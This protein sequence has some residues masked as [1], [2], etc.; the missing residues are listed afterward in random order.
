MRVLRQAFPDDRPQVPQQRR[1]MRSSDSNASV[2]CPGHVV[3]FMPALRVENLLPIDLTYYLKNAD[4]RGT[5]KPG[6]VAPVV[7][8]RIYMFLMWYTLYYQGNNNFDLIKLL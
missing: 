7:A 1:V 8:V 5:V 6:C 2:V 3:T 4:I